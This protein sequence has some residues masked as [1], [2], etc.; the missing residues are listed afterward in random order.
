MCVNVCS[1]VFSLLVF[2]VAERKRSIVRRYS[3]SVHISGSEDNNLF[4]QIVL[5]VWAGRMEE[6][7]GTSYFLKLGDLF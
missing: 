6:D 7:R 5:A 2:G 3:D 1:C 4:M